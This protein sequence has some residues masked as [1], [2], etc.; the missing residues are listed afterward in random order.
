M[1]KLVDNDV[2][3]FRK[4]RVRS[5]LPR[6]I[7]AVWQLDNKIFEDT[8]IPK[9]I[10]QSWLQVYPEGFKVAL[11]SFDK[12]VGY[13]MVFRLKKEEI[14]HKWDIDTG[15][16][17]CIKHNPNGEILY[18]VSCISQ[19]PTVG[20]ALCLAARHLAVKHTELKEIWAYSRLVNFAQWKQENCPDKPI[21][22][23]LD[24]YI[25]LHSDP[26]QLF[27]ESVGCTAVKGIE[28]YLPGDKA[29]LGCAALTKWS[30]PELH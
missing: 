3:Q 15:N 13:I 23:C 5:I 12:I 10:F 2:L 7:E 1:V 4:Y 19:A 14:Q 25:K 17:F 28:G 27:Y 9:Q 18:G 8:P 30:K 21:A 20:T 26:V 24:K 22:F 29:S 16:G 6:E 11:D